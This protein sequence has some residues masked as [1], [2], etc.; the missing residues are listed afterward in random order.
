MDCGAARSHAL[1]STLPT[2]LCS[3][4]AR[5]SF[6]S[7]DVK[8]AHTCAS[9]AVLTRVWYPL[10]LCYTDTFLHRY[11]RLLVRFG[12]FASSITPA[13]SGPLR[14]TPWIRSYEKQVIDLTELR[15]SW[16]VAYVYNKE[17]LCKASQHHRKGL[18]LGRAICRCI[19]ICYYKVR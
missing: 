5:L 14:K 9:A 7:Y 3:F 1:P 6:S 11:P 10:S 4:L 15:G 16:N 2:H 8:R 18:L 17:S 13:D 19:A 12:L